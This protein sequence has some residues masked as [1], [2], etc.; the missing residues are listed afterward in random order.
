M[1]PIVENTNNA[2]RSPDASAMAPTDN[3]RCANMLFRILFAL[4]ALYYG[5]SCLLKYLDAEIGTRVNL[6]PTEQAAAFPSITL[7][8]NVGYKKNVTKGYGYKKQSQFLDFGS[9]P[10]NVTIVSASLPRI[11]PRIRFDKTCLYIGRVHEREP[12]LPV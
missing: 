9:F 3:R 4:V 5:V 10:P 8:W 12:L 2:I 6:V 1:A 7:C 11:F